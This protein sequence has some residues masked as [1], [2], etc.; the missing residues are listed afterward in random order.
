MKKTKKN[1][2]GTDTINR[3]RRDFMKKAATAAVVAAAAPTFLSK[4]S[5]AAM[6]R[7]IKIGMVP[8]LTGPLAVFSEPDNFVMDQVKKLIGDGIMINGTKH[9][10]V[11][12]ARDCR[13]DSNRAAEV[14][15]QFIKSDKVD[16]MLTANT[17]DCVIPV[18]DQCE[19]NGVP[20]ISTNGPAHSYVYGRGGSATKGFD[21]TWH[22]FWEET[23]LCRLYCSMWNSLPTNKVVGCLWPNDVDGN[24]DRVDFPKIIAEA[25]LKLVDAGPF[26]PMSDDFTAQINV[27]KKNNCEILG[28]VLPPPSFTAFWSQCAQQGYRP[29]ILT[30]AK[31]LL[32]PAAAEAL[33]DRRLGLTTEMWWSPYDPFKSSL[34]GQSAK[35]LCDAWESATKKQWTPP[36][37]FKHG[38]FEI[39]L[40]SL[41]RTKDVNS[42]ASIRDAIRETNL[43]TIVGH[44]QWTGKPY[45]NVCETP[46]VG[47][48]W[49]KGK[50]FKYELA[51]V[52][53]STFKTI[54]TQRALKSLV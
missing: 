15:S 25:G 14:A 40:D 51:V 5:Y 36:L 32:F 7:P 48:Q 18:A 54:P 20:C 52:N 21:W 23:T 28:G 9:P 38:L 42:P 26:A 13:S 35:Q 6:A 44:I 11:V 45:K 1:L 3:S 19:L 50:R 33:G 17:P 16:L 29:K 12:I 37:G 22:F 24:S 30:M 31:A 8:T 41:K 4:V 47:G 43:D 2:P 39:A 53:N 34:T 27:F 49:V 10:I 46:L